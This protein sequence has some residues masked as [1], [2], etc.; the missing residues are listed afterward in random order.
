MECTSRSRK[1]GFGPAVL[2]DPSVTDAPLP[3]E[4]KTERNIFFTG[5]YSL[6]I[7]AHRRKIPTERT[8][9]FVIGILVD[10]LGI[11]SS[12]LRKFISSPFRFITLRIE[13]RGERS[14]I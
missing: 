1:L 13:L 5:N 9:I 11:A 6:R 14:A 8:S 10:Y 3:S 2:L 12:S 7:L 4:E